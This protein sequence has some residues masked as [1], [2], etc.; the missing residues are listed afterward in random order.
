[1]V[2]TVPATDVGLTVTVTAADVALEQLPFVTKALK[3]LVAVNAPIIAPVNGEAVAPVMFVK[4]LLSG[5]DC[6]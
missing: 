1:L 2:E 5:D 3:Y 6:H 4:V